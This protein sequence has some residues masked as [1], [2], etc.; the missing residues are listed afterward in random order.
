MNF[1]P[2]IQMTVLQSRSTSP[3]PV[4]GMITPGTETAGGAGGFVGGTDVP[5]GT[6]VPVCVAVAVDVNVLVAVCVAV[7]V[8][9]N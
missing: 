2:N 3:V 5:V 9:V 4:S 8:E 1:T 7:G 6:L